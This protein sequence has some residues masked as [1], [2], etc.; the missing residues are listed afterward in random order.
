MQKSQPSP[1]RDR[2]TDGRKRD[3]EGGIEGRQAGDRGI[4]EGV[5]GRGE[6]ERERERMCVDEGERE[7][8]EI[9]RQ[10]QRSAG[11]EGGKER[12]KER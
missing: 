4:T 2:Q 1:T 8:D 10:P 3:L 7:R 5:R 6:R 12:D 9:K 11:R